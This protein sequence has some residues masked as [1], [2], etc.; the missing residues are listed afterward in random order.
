MLKPRWEDF[1]TASQLAQ[2]LGLFS[3]SQ[4][5]LDAS[6]NLMDASS[7][8]NQ[9][10]HFRVARMKQA[11]YR[12]RLGEALQLHEELGH[13]D[14]PPSLM[15]AL[16]KIG[17]YLQTC[18]VGYGEDPILEVDSPAENLWFES[19]KDRD[20]LIVG[21]G[22]TVDL[23]PI[24]SGF[25]VARILGPGVWEWSDPQDI[26]ANVTDAVYSIPEVIERER[27]SQNSQFFAKLQDYRFVN[28][29]K[30]NVLAT[31]NSRRVDTFSA[32]FSRGH[33]QMIPLAVLDVLAH[34]GRPVVV[35]SDFFQSEN[36]YRESDRRKPGPKPQEVSGSDG[37][38]FDRSAL[39]A[40][41]SIFENWSLVK[42]LADAGHVRGDEGF[43]RALNCSPE[44][45]FSRYDEVLGK[46]RV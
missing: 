44:E 2:S 10:I 18:T 43:M 30:E 23:P 41:H 36:A 38:D 42:N 35:G 15:K 9:S 4:K 7:V 11:I 14:L 20:V 28:V 19:V 33:P 45:L 39:M 32:L 24:E 8:S 22:Q 1:A 17:W 25:L 26:V 6:W 31:P 16:K 5:F 27:S 21:P 34:S 37:G 12:G 3:A 40:S 29:K 46:Q 13:N